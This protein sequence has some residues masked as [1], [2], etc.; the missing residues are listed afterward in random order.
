MIFVD[1]IDLI[2]ENFAEFIGVLGNFEL[3]TGITVLGIIIVSTVSGILVKT[4]VSRGA[5]A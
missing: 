3:G 2:V 1:L 4:F 5:H